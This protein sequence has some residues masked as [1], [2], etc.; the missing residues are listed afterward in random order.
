MMSFRIF[1]IKRK[2]EDILIR[3]FVGIGRDIALK[4]PLQEEF[5]I[6]FFFPFYHTGGAE[7]VHAALVN[8]FRDRKCVVLFTRKSNDEGFKSEFQKSG[9]KILDISPYTDNKKKYW[10]NLVWRGLISAHINRQKKKPLVINGQCNFAYKISPWIKKEIPQI[11]L[12]H[13]FNSF[14]AI[15]I[16]FLPFYRQTVMISTKAIEQYKDQYLR[17]NVPQEYVNKIKFISNGIVVPAE[18]NYKTRSFEVVKV[19][20]SGRSTPEKRVQLAAKIAAAA[21]E[22]KLSAQFTFVG[23]IKDAVPSEFKD[24]IRLVGR[25]ISVDEM[26]RFYGESDVILITSSEEGFPMAIMEGM[27]YGCI[28]MATPVGD[29][30]NRIKQPENGIIFT[31]VTNEAEIVRQSLDFLKLL[32]KDEV[33][34]KKIAESN[35]RLAQENFSIEKF[36][37]EWR[38]LVNAQNNVA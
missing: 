34:R 33:Y 9:H 25:V 2:L 31:S 14:A 10:K 27:A 18:T 37:A 13:S 38:S 19:L 20:Y 32:L 5:D 24:A 12:I 1:L 11:E 15:R 8:S 22:E 4:N 29:I 16:P 36:Q 21:K 23:E 35:H 17:L 26:N 30:P 7:K 6:Y 28:V 3:I